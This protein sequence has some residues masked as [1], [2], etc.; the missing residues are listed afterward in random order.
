MVVDILADIIQ[1]VVLAA[2]PDTL[3][4]IDGARQC[5]HFQIGITGSQEQ[6]FVLIHSG[7]GKEEGRIIDGNAGRRGP[8]TVSM[9][10]DKEINERL[11]NFRHGPVGERV[12]HFG[13]FRCH[14]EGGFKKTSGG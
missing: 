10:L 2:C 9:L 5:T 12:F 1:I 6:G 13:V 14:D 7:I 3:L 11:T 8:E 4:S